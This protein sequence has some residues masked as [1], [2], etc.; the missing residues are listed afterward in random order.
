MVTFPFSYHAGFNCG[1]NCAEV[2][3]CGVCVCY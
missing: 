3:A 1:F 2:L